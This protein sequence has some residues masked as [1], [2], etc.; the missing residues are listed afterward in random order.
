MATQQ[1]SETLARY[2][3]EQISLWEQSGQSRKS[4]CQQHDL[5]YHR[6]GYWYQKFQRHATTTSDLDSTGFVPVQLPQSPSSS[7]LSIELPSGLTL[8]GISQENLA[9]VT[10][11]VRCL[12]N[13][14]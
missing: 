14:N 2:W 9:L 4:F 13:V 5:N 6:F 8:R 3:Q 10:Q 12:V 1:E 11:L 7:V